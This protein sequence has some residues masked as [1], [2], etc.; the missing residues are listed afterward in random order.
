MNDA[1][2]IQ[3][4]KLGRPL[5]DAE[6]AK[7]KSILNERLNS[8]TK[9]TFH[10]HNNYTQSS[11]NADS[12][13]LVNSLSTGKY[14]MTGY[15]VLYHQHDE[16]TNLPALLLSDLVTDRDKAKHKEF[17]HTNDEDQSTRNY[18]NKIQKVIKVIAN[19]W[20]GACSNSSFILFNE[21]SGPSITY[22]GYCIIT[23]TLMSLEAWINNNVMFYTYDEM[24]TFVTRIVSEE[25]KYNTFEVIDEQNQKSVEQVASYLFEK[26][27]FRP[28]E[29]QREKFT[30]FLSGVSAEDLIR[31]YYKRNMLEFMFSN[32][33]MLEK[34]SAC[35]STEFLD[36]NM[37]SKFKRDADN[38]PEY[39][40][41]GDVLLEKDTVLDGN[42][43]E[44]YSLLDEFVTYK[45]LYEHRARVVQ[46]MPRKTVLTCDTD[47]VFVR[48]TDFYNKFVNTFDVPED[49]D[50]KIKK[51]CI[52]NILTLMV[53]KYLRTMMDVFT[54]NYNIKAEDEQKKIVFKS[55][56]LFDRIV[57]TSNKKHY[58]GSVIM[59]EGKI[60]RDANK[61]VDVK[62]L[63][64]KKSDTPKITR[65]YFSDMLT[66]DIIL[67]DKINAIEIF[68]KYRSFEQK[69]RKDTMEDCKTSFL[70]PAKFNSVRS[71]ANP[72]GT[73]SVRGVL[74]WNKLYPTSKINNFEKVNILPLTIENEEQLNLITNKEIV[75]V[76]R[77]M[78]FK[79]GAEMAGRDVVLALPK[80]STEFPSEFASV[81]T[82]NKII[83]LNVGSIKPIMATLGFNCIDKLKTN[84]AVTNFI[85]I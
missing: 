14:V 42:M 19:S 59:Q 46:T 33:V 28:T 8:R 53:S 54:S 21:N 40:S 12:L 39:S 79:E 62:G 15:G 1:K 49:I 31:I 73:Q 71:Y 74:L 70:I 20:F 50:P 23:N 5:N 36:P 66:Y 80:A 51:I 38:N 27:E 18:Y 64:I 7:L 22:T 9:R 6:L 76:I 16:A 45:Y 24:Y 44:L 43:N 84:S 34:L 77:D 69:I 25:R 35:F 56:F 37:A 26:C 13:A 11:M 81:V 67:K 83:S 68:R 29:E 4:I 17:E 75:D 32:E 58:A 57:L 30:K 72:N 78:Y 65:D 52:A 55:E 48:L 41:K 3:E 2:R 47:S 60:I 63:K 85:K 82:I 61:S 10:I